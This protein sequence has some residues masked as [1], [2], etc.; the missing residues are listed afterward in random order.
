MPRNCPQCGFPDEGGVG[1]CLVCGE[2][3]Y[4]PQQPQMTT[5]KKTTK[6]SPPKLKNFIVVI[7]IL[8]IFCAA[9]STLSKDKKKTEESVDSVTEKYAE[10]ENEYNTEQN[11][12]QEGYD[13]YWHDTADVSEQE[14]TDVKA[15]IIKYA[16]SQGYNN[17]NI[18]SLT[19]V[20]M[21][22]S[23]YNREIMSSYKAPEGSDVFIA[24]FFIDGMKD[25]LLH[26]LDGKTTVIRKDGEYK[27]LNTVFSN[28][29]Y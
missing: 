8:A 10:Y 23:N 26:V 3:F 19:V 6:K 27:H 12:E 4:V 13:L 5:K 1:H 21:P 15:E 28:D 18:V 17:I 22:A 11:T 2:P 16:E 25:G 7:L 24:D 20:Q 14:V 29:I 9:F